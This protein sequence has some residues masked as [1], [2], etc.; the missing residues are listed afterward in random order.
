MGNRGWADGKLG[1]NRVGRWAKEGG[2]WVTGGG[3]WAKGRVPGRW[4]KGRL[5]KWTK[6]QEGWSNGQEGVGQWAMPPPL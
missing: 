6:V 2:Q 1:N 4:T 5:G 3:Q